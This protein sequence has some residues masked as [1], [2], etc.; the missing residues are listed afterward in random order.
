MVFFLDFPEDKFGQVL[1]IIRVNE[2]TSEGIVLRELDKNG[3][4]TYED[5]DINLKE[6]IIKPYPPLKAGI[7]ITTSPVVEPK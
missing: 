3:K 2:K 6:N 4:E 1:E 5:W 7:K